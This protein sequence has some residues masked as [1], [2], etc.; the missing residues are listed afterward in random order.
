LLI[1]Q[2]LPK[3]PDRRLHA[4]PHLAPQPPQPLVA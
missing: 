4:R 1:M 2:I 3:L